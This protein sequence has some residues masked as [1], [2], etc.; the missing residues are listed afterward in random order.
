M[1]Q[2]SSNPWNIRRK[3]YIRTS[4][5]QPELSPSQSPL[6]IRSK[7]S[8]NERE[9]NNLIHQQLQSEL[10]NAEKV[11]HISDASTPNSGLISSG[12]P[13]KRKQTLT[14]LGQALEKEKLLKQAKADARI[15][16]SLK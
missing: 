14:V 7:Y 10:L 11:S 8:V 3:K 9:E 4:P 15:E 5:L 1:Q 13:T 16:K 2:Y 6:T 12:L